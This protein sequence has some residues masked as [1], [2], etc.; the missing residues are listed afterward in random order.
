MATATT[1]KTGKIKS[2][3]AL[4]GKLPSPELDELERQLKLFLLM[5]EAQRFDSVKPKSTLTMKEIVEE[6]KKVRHARK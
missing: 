2:I 6:V 4:V 1:T 3:T 5:I